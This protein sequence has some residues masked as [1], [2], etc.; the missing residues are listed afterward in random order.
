VRLLER[1]H[2]QDVAQTFHASLAIPG[3]TG[4]VKRRMRGTPAERCR[5][6]TGTLRDVSTLAGYCATAGGRE[7]GFALLFNRV[8]IAAA[9]AIQ[10]RI[11]AAIARLDEPSSAADPGGAV[12]PAGGG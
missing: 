7:L 4:T 3:S 9:Q 6:K 8:N 2:G 11:A 5:V 10:N 12:P 1:M